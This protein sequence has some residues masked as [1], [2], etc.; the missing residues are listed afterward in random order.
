MSSHFARTGYDCDYLKKSKKQSLR[1]GRYKLSSHQWQNNNKCNA[2]NGPRSDRVGNTGE[3]NCALPSRTDIESA[4]TNR[5][6]PDCKRCNIT[7]NE[8]NKITDQYSCGNVAYCQP[9]IDFEYSR[10]NHP[11][12][13]FRG[14]STYNLQLGH[15]LI[16]PNNWTFHSHNQCIASPDKIDNV[17]EGC[18]TRLDAKD[19]YRSQVYNQ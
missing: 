9:E 1:P 14:L 11:I 15:P 3:F 12:D 17:R 18:N 2:S 13:N 19:T 10:L 16:H 4:L 7:M 6:R 8:K 5:G